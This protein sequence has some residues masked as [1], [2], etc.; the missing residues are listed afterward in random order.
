MGFAQAYTIELYQG[1]VEKLLDGN[2]SGEAY[3][4][5]QHEIEII[6]KA[7][8]RNDLRKW[9]EKRK[10]VSEY[11]HQEEKENYEVKMMGWELD[12]PKPTLNS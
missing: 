3:D 1:I 12:N 2:D 11:L 4:W 5:N 9:F 8:Y 10:V 7:K 6:C